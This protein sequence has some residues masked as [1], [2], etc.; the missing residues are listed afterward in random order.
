LRGIL[1]RC[2]T[3]TGVLC[4]IPP[5]A[6]A[7]E[8][9][10]TPLANRCDFV[11]VDMFQS[12]PSDGDAYILKAIIHDWSDDKA[13]QILRNCRQGISDSGKA[14]LIEFV[15]KP[16][17]QP[18]FAKWLD[19]NMLVILRGR[20]RT[21]EEFRTLYAAAGFRLN[22][23]YLQAGFRSSKAFRWEGANDLFRNQVIRQ[24]RG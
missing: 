3:T 6:E 4:D 12:V 15:V 19:L 5:V 17:N 10:E 13:I 7:S 2:P 22:G 18:D 14:L 11:G 16:S 20:E 8:I 23:S 1:E 21:E 24:Q 9:R